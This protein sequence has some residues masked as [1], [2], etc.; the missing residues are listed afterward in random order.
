MNVATLLKALPLLSGLP[1][2]QLEALADHALD[3]SFSPGARIVS[4]DET[5]RT[6]FIV[7]SGRVKVFKS[8]L[9]GKEQTLYIMGPGEPLGLCTAFGDRNSPVSAQ[10]LEES[11]L[12]LFPGGVLEE[13]ATEEPAL[14]LNMLLVISRRLRESMAMIEALALQE[15]PQRLAGF[16]LHSLRT[17]GEENKGALGLR[18]S[19]PKQA[20][21]PMD[22]QLGVTQRELAKI[23]GTTPETLN[24][25]LKRMHKDGLLEAH[26]RNV[27]IHDLHALE[28]VA[29][30]K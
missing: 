7:I 4:E 2:D 13:M 5:V 15:M 8:S 16:L 3:K 20:T 10:A 14:M 28:D 29:A 25:V 18:E 1:D 6:Y 26:G 11:R 19:M 27:R 12:L 30:G 23:L 21:E 24:R 9:E 17:Q 22:V